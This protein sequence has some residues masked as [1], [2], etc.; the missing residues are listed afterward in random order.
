MGGI[1]RVTELLISGIRQRPDACE[2]VLWGH[3]R[4]AHLAGEAV[5]WVD[6]HSD[7]RRRFGQAGRTRIPSGDVT[8]FMCQTRPLAVRGPQVVV[9]Y[10]TIQLDFAPSRRSR[11]LRRIYLRRSAQAAHAVLTISNQSRD[12]IVRS[13]GVDAHRIGMLRICGLPRP[14]VP[15][16]DP[17]RRGHLLYVGSLAAHKN[18][19]FVI[20][21]FGRTDFAARGGTLYLVGGDEQG[22]EALRAYPPFGNSGQVRIAGRVSDHD[23]EQAYAQA[24]ALV[25]ASLAE[26]F[27]LPA[28]EAR[29][30]GLPLC[31]SG[32]GAMSNITGGG[33]WVFDP[34]DEESAA[35]AMDTAI[36]AGQGDQG[37]ARWR[38]AMR[39]GPGGGVAAIAEDVADAA[40]VAIAG[41]P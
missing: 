23:L 4:H 40:R 16:V 15:C 34:T 29:L 13:L 5:E 9:V 11:F 31:H 35:R 20:R 2:W 14:E 30:R 24:D 18:V 28:H 32:R 37:W 38:R 1:G 19:P 17:S 36:A 8:V 22:A 33:I 39:A 25:Q 26:G 21:A 6:E 10:D 41:A 7:P 3:P 27:G 12:D